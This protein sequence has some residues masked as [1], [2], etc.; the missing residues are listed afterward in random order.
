M[1]DEIEIEVDNTERLM[2]ALISKMESMD[3]KLSKMEM[4]VNSPNTL[5][6]KAGYVAYKT[7]LSEDVQTDAFRNDLADTGTIMKGSSNDGTDMSNQEIH[8][9]SWE[10][11]H[12]MASQHKDVDYQEEY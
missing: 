11:I 6:K 9:M 3:A 8:E 4:Q 5:L 2:N 10:E 1:A 12:E 7:P